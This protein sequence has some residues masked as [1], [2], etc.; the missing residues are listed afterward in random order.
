V[1][2]C[3]PPCPPTPRRRCRSS[4]GGRAGSTESPWWSGRAP[5]LYY[6]LNGYLVVPP[7]HSLAG[8]FWFSLP[9]TVLVTAL[10]WWAAPVVAAHLPAR[11]AVL[12]LRDYGVLGLVRHRWYVTGASALAGAATHVTWDG[13]THSPSTP[14]GWGVRLLPG[15]AHEAWTGTPWWLFLQHTSTVV[16]AIAA[17]AVAVHVGRRRLLRAWHGEPPAVARTPVAFWTVAAAVTALYPVTW[18]L[19][20]DRHAAHVQGVR[21]VWTVT[22]ALLAAA[23][24]S[25][26][27]A[28]RHARHGARRES[29][30]LAVPAR[31]RGTIG[32]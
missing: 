26:L 17:L 7:T 18:P 23:A 19:L 31:A 10:V 12:A 20:H 32:P 4:C 11:P 1:P 21:L 14:H 6:A 29:A 27:V 5:D 22:L 16:G 9:V 8:L 13:F 28:R 2:P 25:R 3:R 15:L 24:A 30:D